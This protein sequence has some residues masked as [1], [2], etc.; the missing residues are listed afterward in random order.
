M[1][2]FAGS[3]SRS[4]SGL[5]RGDDWLPH[6]RCLHALPQDN[7]LAQLSNARDAREFRK[8]SPVAGLAIHRTLAGASLRD[9]EPGIHY[10]QVQ[11]QSG[12]RA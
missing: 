7:G 5:A 9:Y 2:P 10:S 8:L 4:A 1:K 11:M 3:R 12:R 6:G